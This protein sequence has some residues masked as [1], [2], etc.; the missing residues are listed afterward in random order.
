VIVCHSK[1]PDLSKE[2]KQADVVIV[3]VG[4][5]KLIGADHIKKDAIVIDIGI[6]KMPDSSLKGDV[7]FEAVKDVASAISPVPG[8]VG[9]MTVLGLFENVIDACK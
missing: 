1:T 6:S 4:T 2:T 7:D 8:G 9:P 3:A 5:P